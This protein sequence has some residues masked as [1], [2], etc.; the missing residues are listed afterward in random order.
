MWFFKRAKTFEIEMNAKVG[1]RIKIA[2]NLWPNQM[3]LLHP[4]PLMFGGPRRMDRRICVVVRSKGWNE[5]R[6]EVDLQE[7]PYLRLMSIERHPTEN[8]VEE[9]RKTLVRT[10]SRTIW[11]RPFPQPYLQVPKAYLPSSSP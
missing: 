2:S 7:R 6:I 5:Q 1:T 10:K 4:L 9:T 8:D 11:T 3:Q